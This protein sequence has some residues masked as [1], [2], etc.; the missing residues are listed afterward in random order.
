[1]SSIYIRDGRAPIPKDE[2]ISRLMSAIRAKNTVP[3]L[4]VRRMLLSVGIKGY[5][6]HQKQISGRP[7]IVFP[8]KRVAIFIHGCFWHGCSYC[9][10]KLPKTHRVFWRKKILAN[11]L[12][13]VRK[14]RDLKKSGWQSFTIWACR[15]R[16]ERGRDRVLKRICMAVK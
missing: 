16:T 14:I 6:L 1:M 3:E 2:R 5:R 11:K 12:R 15:L 13:D 4:L 8:K 7:D 10:P 9:K